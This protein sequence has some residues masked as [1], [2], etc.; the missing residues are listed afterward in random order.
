MTKALLS[1]LAKLPTE[2][3]HCDKLRDQLNGYSKLMFNQAD[4][5]YLRLLLYKQSKMLKNLDLEINDPEVEQVENLLKKIDSL[6]D[7]EEYI[8]L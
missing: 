8:D 4:L 3:W 6:I 5:H 2:L 7:S 1:R